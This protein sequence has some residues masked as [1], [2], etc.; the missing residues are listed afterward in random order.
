MLSRG[1]PKDVTVMRVEVSGPR[2]YY[3]DENEVTSMGRTTGYTAAI[4]ARMVGRGEVKGK[5]VHGPESILDGPMVARL[6]RE[7]A[8]KG[9]KISSHRTERTNKKRA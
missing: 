2:D 3:D 1:D 6:L 5:G 4:I 9:V 8:G 7:L